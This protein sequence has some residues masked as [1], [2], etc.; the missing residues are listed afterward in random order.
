MVTA[1]SR[2]HFQVEIHSGSHSWHS[3]EAVEAGGQD[4]GPNPYELLLGALAACKIIT[5]KM[6]AQKR[7]GN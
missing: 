7:D 1:H 2:D 5:V 3:D 4:T 6:Y